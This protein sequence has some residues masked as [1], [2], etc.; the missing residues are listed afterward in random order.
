MAKRDLSR[1]ELFALVWERPTSEIAKKLGISDVAVG[2]LC[3]KLQVPKPP[4]GDW[5]RVEAGQTPWRSALRA[6]REEL[7]AKRKSALRARTAGHLTELQLKILDA[8]LE[9]LPTGA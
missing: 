1:E 5:A 6:F 7:E 9:E 8:A 2:K 3:E 4:Q